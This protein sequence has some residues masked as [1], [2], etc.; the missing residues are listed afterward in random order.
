MSRWSRRD[1][2]LTMMK[3]SHEM[4]RCCFA[5]IVDCCSQARGTKGNAEMCK[6]EATR[7]SDAISL[8]Y[9]SSF[10]YLYTQVREEQFEGPSNAAT[11]NSINLAPQSTKSTLQ[12][13]LRTARTKTFNMNYGQYFDNGLDGSYN[14]V[15][16]VQGQGSLSGRESSKSV[17]VTTAGSFFFIKFRRPLGERDREQNTP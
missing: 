16:T 2:Q 5:A 1:G 11:S 15:N 4:A 9:L 13:F 12:R 8:L 3:G 7:S 17:S 14:S 10:P 6:R